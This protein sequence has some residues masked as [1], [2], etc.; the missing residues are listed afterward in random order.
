MMAE[1]DVS[2]ALRCSVCGRNGG[3]ADCETVGDG[4]ALIAGLRYMLLTGLVAA[5]WTSDADG[6]LVCPRCAKE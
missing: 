5:G 3:T 1:R 2:V 6:D 4:V